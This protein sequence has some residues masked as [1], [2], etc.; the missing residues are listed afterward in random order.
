MIS[1]YLLMLGNAA[2]FIVCFAEACEN[3]GKL[4]MEDTQC[5]FF[6]QEGNFEIP[7]IYGTRLM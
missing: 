3:V 5:P 6:T 1:G 2:M 4:N 7:P